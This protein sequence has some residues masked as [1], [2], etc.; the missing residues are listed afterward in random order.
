MISAKLGQTN[1]RRHGYMRN[2]MA[3]N[4]SEATAASHVSEK[5]VPRVASTSMPARATSSRLV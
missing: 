5:A 2:G 1:M 3:P 4:N